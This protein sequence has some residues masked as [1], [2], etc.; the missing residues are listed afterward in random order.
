MIH[1]WRTYRLKP[2][3]ANAYLTLL[4]DEGLPLVTRYLPLM[5]YWLAETGMLNAIHHLWAY[6]DWAEREKARTALAREEGWTAGFIPKAF[7]MVEAQENRFLQIRRS[8]PAYDAALA[9]RREV[10]P[11]RLAGSQLLAGACAVLLTG[12]THEAAVAEWLPLS[13]SDDRTVTLLGRDENP[14]PSSPLA[15]ESHVILRPLAFSPL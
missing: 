5:G 7:P 1:E 6:A 15:A 14:V 3:A 13:G 10:R 11:A 2:G 4:A 9:Q 12:T 8:S